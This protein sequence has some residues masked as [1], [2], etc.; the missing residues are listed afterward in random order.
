MRRFTNPSDLKR[1]ILVHTGEK[2]YSCDIC[3]TCFTHRTH[4]K[5]HK[6]VHTGDKPYTCDSCG[7]CFITSFQMKIHKTATSFFLPHQ[8]LAKS[9][10]I[11]CGFR[12]SKSLKYDKT[13]VKG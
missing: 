13:N 1:H 4:L 10:H 3:G 8:N 7:K 2:P 11:Y 6:R 5:R 12:S 9:H